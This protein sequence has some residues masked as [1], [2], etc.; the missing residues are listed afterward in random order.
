MRKIAIVLLCLL[1]MSCK[2]EERKLEE[3]SGSSEEEVIETPS[4]LSVETEPI[5]L[6]LE[7]ANKLAQLPLDCID[8]EYPNKLNQ[9]LAVGEGL[10]I[11]LQFLP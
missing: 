2:N 8:V 4:I 10:K 3:A 6:T 5:M 11:C 1:V 9:T 7:Q